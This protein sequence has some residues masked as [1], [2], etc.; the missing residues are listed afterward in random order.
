METTNIE[1]ISSG[2]DFLL[3]LEEAAAFL[4]IKKSWL[5]QLTHFRKIPYFKR[6]RKL[7]FSKLE[8]SGWLLQDRKATIFELERE[9]E[10]R[11]AR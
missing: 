7:Y 8:L 2:E 10:K 11:L 6:G 4:K 5:Y 3:G 9:A 1:K